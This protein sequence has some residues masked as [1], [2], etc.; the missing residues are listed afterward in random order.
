MNYCP[1]NFF[2]TNWFH[3]VISPEQETLMIMNLL[4]III[5]FFIVINNKM[6]TRINPF[7]HIIMYVCS[8][9]SRFSLVTVHRVF[10]VLTYY[11]KL[12]KIL[13]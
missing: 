7:I 2:F 11:T 13:L 8:K 6:K 5:R 10:A 3:T 1:M 9:H 4:V 12:V